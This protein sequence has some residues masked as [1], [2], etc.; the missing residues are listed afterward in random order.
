MSTSSTITLRDASGGLQ[1]FVTKGS[2]G[3][4]VLDTKGHHTGYI[5]NDGKT[6][7]VRM[8]ILSFQPRLDLIS[9]VRSSERR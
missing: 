8:N 9:P 6:R 1:G 5:D 4:T 3:F 2:S 7:D